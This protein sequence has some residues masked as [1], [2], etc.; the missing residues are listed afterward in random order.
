MF[1]VNPGLFVAPDALSFPGAKSPQRE[2][3]LP[4]NFC[5]VEHSLPGSEKSKNF[6]SMELLH[7]WNFRS[8]GA[9]V[10]R[11]FASWK[12]RTLELSLHKQLSYP[13]TFASVK[14]SLAFLKSCGK[15]ESNVSIGVFWQTFAA[16]C[17]QCSAAASGVIMTSRA[18]IGGSMPKH[19]T[20]S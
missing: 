14:H 13:L 6:H 15:Q 1:L 5:C 19:S 17:G 12:I 10:P 8:S 9:N 4:S 2:L 16:I 20:A 3:S 11:T 18:G 7:P